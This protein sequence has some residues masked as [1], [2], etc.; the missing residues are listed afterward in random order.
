MT[1][2]DRRPP[3]PFPL[4]IVTG[5]LGAGKTSLLNRL[6]RDPALADTLVI[7]NEFG[8]IG[9]DHLL[10]E[11]SGDD[12]L[13]MT[14]GCLCCSIRGDLI[15]TLEDVLRRRDNGRITPFQRVL[16]E[17][18]GLADPAPVLHTIMHHPYLMLRFRLDGVVTLV[19]AVNGAATLDAHEE[20]VKQA[21][22][23]DRLVI[24]KTDLLDDDAA[25]GLPSLRERLAGLNPGALQLDAA[26]G[27]ATAAALLH[28]GLYDPERKSP[29]VRRWLNAEA[30]ALD[31]PRGHHRAGHNHTRHDHDVNRHDARIR[32]FCMRRAE[33]I[34]PAAFD[35]FLELLRN[36]HGPSLLRVK[37]IVA[38]SDDPSR[39]VVIH[40]VQHVFHPPARLPA[41]PDD[42]RDTRVIFIL[43]D[44]EPAFVEGL[45]SAFTGVPAIDR[46][47]GA[48]LAANPLAPSARG[49]LA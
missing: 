47:D 15:T 46:A 31:E 14:S 26:K 40:G 41:W 2:L 7:I 48:A 20:A 27:E 23:A 37:G 16:I 49:L 6:L 5:F 22:M 17:T 25:A 36:A 43:R 38:L 11:K 29:N 44:L 33:A 9:L 30:F 32:A 3:P 24:A 12:M 1:D 42:D 8:E 21:A 19:D 34:A 10:V 45:W 13:V 18:T 39:P 28:A 4:T 35:L